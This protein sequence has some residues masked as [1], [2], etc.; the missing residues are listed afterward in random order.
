MSGDGPKT[1]YELAMERLRQKDRESAVEE[2]RPL[3]D[4]QKVSIAEARNVYQAK[5]AEREILHQDAL[6]KA[7]SHEEIE[8]LN[9]EMGRDLERLAGERDRKIDEIRKRGQGR[10][11]A[12]LIV[13]SAPHADR[14]REWRLALL[15]SRRAR[16]PARA[17]PRLR[18]RHP[19]LGPPGSRAVAVPPRDRL[20]RA[21]PRAVG[22]AARGRGVLPSDVGR[23]S[24]RAPRA[25]EDRACG[26]RRTLHGREHCAEL[27]PRPSSNGQRADRR[28]HRR[29][30]RGGRR[31][32]RGTA[33][34][35][36]RPEPWRRGGIRRHGDGAPALRALRGPGAGG[37]AARP[38]LSHDPS[39]PGPRPHRPRGLGQAAEHLQPRRA[40]A[41]AGHAHA[42]D[43]RRVRHA[44]P[45]APPIHGRRHAEGAP[46]RPAWRGPPDESGSACGV[47]RRGE[48]ALMGDKAETP[49]RIRVIDDDSGNV[50]LLER[51]LKDA[52]YRDVQSTTDSRKAPA[53]YQ[54]FQPDLIL[55][56]LMMPYLDGVAVI[57]QLSIP[58]DVYLPVL[59]LTADVTLEAKQRALAA[60]AKDFLAKPFD[61][62]EVLLRIK[63][64]LDTRRLYI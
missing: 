38:F 34:V 9:K 8:K 41:R 22:R 2:Q 19:E 51:F 49:A 27:R 18:V 36:G 53:L 54:T 14:P 57:Q 29:R 5:V 52:G 64:L 30:L 32:G 23:R 45:E 33:R 37:R 26:R 40:L 25:P 15:R 55:L 47:Q 13:S 59:V 56:D 63:K 16:R 28:R 10:A 44:L 31:L 7:K 61:R 12:S 39:G 17:R 46:R 4:A 42:P 50:R 6:A 60:G 24:A 35:R 21:R 43:R 62:L 48:V 11:A 20:R 3:T 1:A 58:E